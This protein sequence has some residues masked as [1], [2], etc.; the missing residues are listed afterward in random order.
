LKGASD[1]GNSG[2][3]NPIEKLLAPGSSVNNNIR[4]G[5][6]VEVT[7][8][9]EGSVAIG[10]INVFQISGSS[11]R[12][13]PKLEDAVDQKSLV[14]GLGF[15]ARVSDGTTSQNPV[16][17]IL[18]DEIDR[19]RDQI[20]IG[21][22]PT[23]LRMLHGMLSGLPA[24]A[25]N[26]VI[27]RIKANIGH[28][29]LHLDEDAEAVRWLS[30]AYETAPDEPKA[31][32]NNVL[33]LIIAERFSA[34]FDFAK[35]ALR[36]DPEN[37]YVVAYLLQAAAF[38]KEVPDPFEFVPP[39]LR[40]RE[41]VMLSRALYLKVQQKRPEWWEYSR[42]IAE[43]F[44][45]N[46]RIQFVA[47]ESH[48][49]E[50]TYDGEFTRGLDEDLRSRLKAAADVFDA[51]WSKVK[52]SATPNRRQG[53]QALADGMVARQVLRQLD[54]AVASAEELVERTTDEEILLNLAQIAHFSDRNELAKRALD[55]IGNSGRAEFLRAM[56]NMDRNEWTEAVA[57]F[58]RAEIQEAER[59]VVQTIKALLPLRTGTGQVDAASFTAARAVAE[60]DPRG[61]VILARVAL[62][63]GLPDVAQEAIQAAVVALDEDS[64]MA[65]R[66][67]V[68]AYASEAGD[69][70]R[71]ILALDGR[72]PENV[73]SRDLLTL[74]EAHAREHPKRER[75]L[76]FFERL[77][78]EV[79]EITEYARC[80]ASVLLDAGKAGDAERI[81]R[82]I[83]R[84]KPQDVYAHLRLFESL[85][86]LRRQP[87]VAAIVL[88][89]D[90]LS[91]QGPPEYLMAFAHA[92]RDARANDRALLLAY[93]LV[94]TS[95]E[96]P[97]I[98][99]G[100]V[101]L[102]L[103]DR[104]QK[105]IPDLK[106]V[107]EGA[108]VR[109]Q[110]ETTAPHDFTIEEGPQ[111]LGIE[112]LPPNDGLVKLVMGLAVGQTFTIDKG[113]L[114]SET[115]KVVEINSKYLHLLHVI[116]DSFER[117]YPSA[118]GLWR[119]DV[120]DNNLDAVFAFI[121][122]KAEADREIANSYIEKG[123]PLAFVARMLGRPAAAFAQFVRSLGSDIFT[124][125]GNN[126][127]RI[128]A[129]AIAAE[130]RGNGAVLDE[131]TAWT[132]AEMGVLD[133]LKTWFG[134]LTTPSSTIASIDRLIRREED[135]LGQESMS[136]AWRDGQFIRV[137]ATDEFAR[138]QIEVLEK[139]RA[140]IIAYCDVEHALV[141]DQLPD[142][143][144]AI[145]EQFGS[146]L[147]DP[148]FLAKSRN[149]VLL[150][151][152]LRFRVVAGLVN[153][154]K[155]LWLQAALGSLLDSGSSESGSIV[156]AYIHLAARRHSHLTLNAEILRE[157][158]E[159]CTVGRMGE[160]ET[161]TEFLGNKAAEMYSHTRV[162]VRFI[163]GLWNAYHGDLK[164]QSATGIVLQQLIRNRSADWGFWLAAFFFSGNDALE[165]YLIDWLC[166][167]F[168]PT[169]P[170]ATGVAGW[171]QMM[172]AA[173]SRR[174][175]R[176]SRPALPQA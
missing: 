142:F 108:W 141:P 93:R 152:D 97:K 36:S 95:P 55:R 80:R 133:L 146:K 38:L 117:R 92:L 79:R 52:S 48:L 12:T 5:G 3:P 129:Y 172:R 74:A 14:S 42:R 83:I 151:D 122:S 13:D 7:V 84:A 29:H 75:N 123:L 144:A 49:D 132:A 85:V 176:V 110:S 72:V 61:L 11:V 115:W 111:F 166:G 45:D 173:R 143:A 91:L 128:A 53:T 1:A 175:G 147:L 4:A 168:L 148:I 9:T 62:F 59:N 112:T 114:P 174:F 118:N 68:A 103:G 66:G 10:T 60:G 167:H 89:A 31:I 69:N 81:F 90:E 98:A 120:K 58:D 32:A 50:A 2:A 125:D 157:V 54:L 46:S 153:G 40:E 37:E 20:V 63:R 67:M 76:R 145:I 15:L 78:R 116:M 34:A 171:R 25:S 156:D 24:S 18:N 169:E 39:A 28:C 26:K 82:G 30:E 51:A 43:R 160:L 64:T 165:R 105:I 8:A 33:S 17:K 106:V 101:S 23:A 87:E 131:Y 71:I 138:Q 107:A 162:T 127:E 88:A 140:D 47:A 44:P 135:S 73:P 86:R 121:R 164:C 163:D 109:L 21:D 96:N 27:F 154:T 161:I 16:E 126:E 94:R 130:A 134:K 41:E 119:V 136:V 57:A 158:Y 99:L 139:L 102:V 56:L 170:V 19:Y 137:D 6:D 124:C 104:E 65:E 159:R 155:G 149:M 113:M 77:P 22:A 35:N 70:K 100:Y 150:S